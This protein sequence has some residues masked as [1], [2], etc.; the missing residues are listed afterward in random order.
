MKKYKINLSPQPPTLARVREVKACPLAAVEE[1]KRDFIF[2]C[3]YL[4]S[5]MGAYLSILLLFV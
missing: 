1:W 3:A 2:N 5:Y 4:L